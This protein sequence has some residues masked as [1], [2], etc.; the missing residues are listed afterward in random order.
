[1][2]RIKVK[3]VEGAMDLSSGQEVTGTKSFSA[4]QQFTGGEITMVAYQDA[5]YWCQREKVLEDAGNSR[6]KIQEGT[7]IIETF[8]GETWERA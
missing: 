6:L 3:Q 4:P 8:N 5:L 2:D 7:L 1:M